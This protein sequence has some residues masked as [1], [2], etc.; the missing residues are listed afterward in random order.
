MTSGEW[1]CP[2]VDE[3][4]DIYRLCPIKEYI[5]RRQATVAAQVV[6]RPIYDICT[7]AGKIPVTRMFMQWWDQGV[8]QEVYQ[9]GDE[10]SL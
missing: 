1:E 8:V 9:T 2:P 4:L 7:G 5:Q 6:F 3:A 10:C